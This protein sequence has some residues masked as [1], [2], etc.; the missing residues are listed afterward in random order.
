M[1][2]WLVA[3][4]A[5]ALP[6]CFELRYLS[7]A[8]HG[9]REISV[10]ARPIED[11]RTDPD[12]PDATK[13]L[14]AHVR[15]VKNF[16]ELSGLRPTDNY[17][18][19]AD[20]QRRAAV[21][22]VSAAEPLSFRT[23]TWS[24]PIVGEVPYLGWFS[25]ADAVAHAKEL[26]AAGWDVSIRPASAYST[27]GWFRDPV[28][29]TML[30]RGTGSV[31]DLAETILHESVHATFYVPGQTPLNESVA[32]FVGEVLAERYLD[33]A[34]GPRSKE[35]LAYGAS[36]R[37]GE[38]RAALLVA[39]HDDLAA[40]YESA[41]PPAEKLAKKTERLLALQKALGDRVLL[42]NAALAQW[43]AYNQGRPELGELLRGCGGDTKR[44]LALLEG[45]RGR[46][47]GNDNREDLGVL[48]ALAGHCIGP[49]GT[50]SP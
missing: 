32:S 37:E 24:F 33:H 17:Q 20:L 27:L 16:G 9:Q 35:R 10:Y 42:N 34:F 1:R 46:P 48:L 29:S 11:V 31:G 6:G 15:Q 12:V 2:R 39:A 44:L 13:A 21:W 36:R 4:A 47:L 3:T 8:A 26:D 38:R 28:L 49:A 18:S 22:V 5:L 19:Y 23:K 25:K 30:S 43:S 45:L 50:V 7:Q 41:A 40:I 14:L